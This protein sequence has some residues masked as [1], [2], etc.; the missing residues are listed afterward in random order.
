MTTSEF[1]VLSPVE[2]EPSEEPVSYPFVVGGYKVIRKISTGGMSNVYLG[3][4]RDDLFAIK[5]SRVPNAQSG[6]VKSRFRREIGLHSKVDSFYVTRLYA[7]GTI[8]GKKYI[9]MEYLDGGTLFQLMHHHIRSGKPMPLTEIVRIGTAIARGLADIAA[10]KII[11]RDLKPS[12]I[13][14]NRRG[15]VKIT[16]FGISTYQVNDQFTDRD[17]A[18]GTPGYMSPEQVGSGVIS[19]RSDIYNLGLILF[20]MTANMTQHTRC[21][22][23][24]GVAPDFALRDDAID[25]YCSD[26]P[27]PLKRI[28]RK[29]LYKDER[30]RYQTAS[31][32]ARDL[33]SCLRETTERIAKVKAITVEADEGVP[34]L[35]R[36]DLIV[37]ITLS[38][39][40][41]ILLLAMIVR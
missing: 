14:L 7:A 37:M 8:D 17:V 21:E 26:A 29:C 12:N 24:I 11:H 2:Q 15:E 34:I 19:E 41:I 38:V 20:E 33:E 36:T 30:L 6:E 3:V 23:G 16:D 40:A 9:A 31:Q 39:V 13:L 35:T 28:I 18:V 25:G 10:A 27:V 4:Q 32:V 22:H 5:I 1:D